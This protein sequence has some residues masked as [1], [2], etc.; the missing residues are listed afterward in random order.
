M[1]TTVTG[2][3]APTQA[4]AQTQAPTEAPA[5]ARTPAPA[6]PPARAGRRRRPMLS[7]GW[8]KAVVLAH[9]IASVGWL[10]MTVV[11]VVLTVAALGLTDPDLLRAAYGFQRLLVGTVIIPSAITTIVTGLV[12][13]LM[14]PWGLVRH[15]W[16]LVKLVA[17]VG[18]IALTVSHSPGAVAYVIEHAATVDAAYRGVQRELVALAVLHPVALGLV[19]WVSFYKPWGRVRR[20]ASPGQA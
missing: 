16:P 1:T 12:L 19:T 20:E 5:Q 11:L 18:T 15:W 10:G 8:R 14:T 9:V 13:S 4:Q 2:L 6:Q 7:R 3:P 17:T